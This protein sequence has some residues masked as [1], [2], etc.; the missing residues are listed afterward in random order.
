MS[1]IENRVF[2][3]IAVG[4]SASLK[5]TIDSRGHRAYLR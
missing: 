1:Y 3:E 4:E 5:R 2:D